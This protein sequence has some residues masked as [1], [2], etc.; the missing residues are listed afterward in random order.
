[1][2]HFRRLCAVIMLACAFAGSALAGDIHCG[3]SLTCVDSAPTTDE[4]VQPV[5]PTDEANST[6]AGSALLLLQGVFSLF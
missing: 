6:L 1:M 4:V 2:S 5:A 3:A